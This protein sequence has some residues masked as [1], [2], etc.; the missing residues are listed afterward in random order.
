MNSR[1]ISVVATVALAI[2]PLGLFAAE[3]QCDPQF[4]KKILFILD[5]FRQIEP[6]MARAD[7][8]KFFMT[9]GGVSTRTARTYVHRSCPHIKVAV[10][11]Q[12]VGDVDR[13][14]E[15]LA[16]KIIKI[17]QPFLQYGRID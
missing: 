9:E 15:S 1:H 10:E 11:F 7:L 4:T 17:S 2:F 14:G 16:D 6:G 3:T 13:F 12:P 8:L 5:E